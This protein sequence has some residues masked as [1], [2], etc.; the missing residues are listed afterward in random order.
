MTRRSLRSRLMVATVMWATGVL[1]ASFVVGRVVLMFHPGRVLLIHNSFIIIIATVLITAGVSV[2]RRGLSPFVVLRERLQ[3]VRS[4]RTSRL[5]GEYPIEV[6]PLV[7]DLNTL[8]EEREHRVS[9]AVAKAGDLA[10]GLKTPLA[11]LA[12]EIDRATAAGQTESATILREQVDRMRRQIDSHLAQARANAGGTLGARA[13]VGQ[14]VQALVRA[15]ERLYAD[16][17]LT[18][19]I[20]VEDGVSVRAPS[21]DLEE[22][23]GNLLDNACKWAS[24]E[25]VIAARA[26]TG[27]V[28]VDVADDGAG[29]SAEM[30]EAVLKRGVRADQTA[31]GSGLGLAIVGDLAEAYGGTMALRSSEQGGLCA[32]LVLPQQV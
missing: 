27:R 12:Q 28:I 16:R 22:M 20:D 30:R 4:G 8:L 9:R 5:E 24:T 3:D 23:L 25:V 29:L 14:A 2:I 6:E 17:K 18:F 32:R 7:D 10:H 19:R 15:M 31:P 21:E 11:I 13:N 26:E 1:A